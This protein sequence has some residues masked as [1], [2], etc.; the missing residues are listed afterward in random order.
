MVTYSKHTDVTTYG[1]CFARPKL[2]KAEQDLCLLR[3]G[4]IVYAESLPF[5]LYCLNQLNV[6]AKLPNLPNTI[7]E[8]M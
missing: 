4:K 1:H 8:F 3:C 2:T 6:H 5:G 7:K